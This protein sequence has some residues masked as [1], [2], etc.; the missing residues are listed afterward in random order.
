[1][2]KIKSIP[3][4]GGIK[5]WFGA[6]VGLLAL[7]GCAAPTPPTATPPLA[8]VY[9]FTAETTYEN[10][11]INQNKL[12]YTFFADTENKCAHWVAQNPCWTENDL[13]TKETNLTESEINALA[14]LIRQTDFMKLGN[15][16]GGAPEGERYYAYT[17]KVKLGDEA[18]EVVYQSFPGAGSKPEAFEK[19]E[20]HLHELIQAKFQ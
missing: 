2:A 15:T 7:E 4:T 10:I 9:H 20:H 11:E 19:L 16:Y 17:L 3:V 12:T 13:Q 6:L 8:I 1:M 18:K 14:S 5:C